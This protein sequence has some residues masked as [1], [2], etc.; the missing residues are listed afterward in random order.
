MRGPT[1]VAA[2]A[3]AA[4]L[5][6][7]AAGAAQAQ[8]FPAAPAFA[9][10]F[11]ARGFMTDGYRDESGALADR[12]VGGTAAAPA[13]FRAVDPQFLYLRLR[14]DATIAQGNGLRPF[15]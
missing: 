9:P 4:A 7:T 13:G 12:D 11:C 8:T 1:I 15:A 6:A 14:L 3:M 2:T 10:F 5:L